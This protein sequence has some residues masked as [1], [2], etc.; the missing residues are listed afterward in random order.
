MSVW[1]SVCDA[2]GR[3]EGGLC[4]WRRGVGGLVRGVWGERVGGA[5][6]CGSRMV[7]VVKEGIRPSGREYLK[8]YIRYWEVILYIAIS[9]LRVL[10][11][12]LI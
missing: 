6:V 2:C 11:I 1:I 3:V 12:D 7:G 5:L 4:E 8:L 9:E 10:Y